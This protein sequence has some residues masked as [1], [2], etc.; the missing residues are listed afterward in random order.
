MSFIRVAIPRQYTE[1]LEVVGKAFLLRPFAVCT[2]NIDIDY[3]T[4]YRFPAGMSEEHLEADSS[5]AYDASQSAV[6]RC[7]GR[8][9]PGQTSVGLDSFKALP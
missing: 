1:G 4:D 2:P 3:F 8:Y 5:G 9:V 6:R 7:L